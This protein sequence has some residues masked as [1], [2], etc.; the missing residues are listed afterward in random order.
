MTRIA[1]ALATVVA[2]ALTAC[3]DPATETR[4]ADLE[5]Q[6]KT[7]NEKVTALETR[8]PGKA[9]AADPAA[10]QAAGELL[11]QA[12]DLAMALKYDEA[13]AKIAELKSK[14]D[15]ITA[16]GV[17]MPGHMPNAAIDDVHVALKMGGVVVTAMRNSMWTDGVE[18]GYKEKFESLIN[19][20]KFA[21]V[22]KE[23]F[24]RGTENGTGLFG[25]Q[26]STLLVL[27]KVAE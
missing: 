12:N 2:L 17:W 22:K 6:V 20:G 19:S 15:V 21:V 18:E 4:I 13:K 11:R 16:S 27:R 7:L 8:A 3:A 24:W 14:F 26:K 25:K 5:T 10:E 9:A 1:P 23:E